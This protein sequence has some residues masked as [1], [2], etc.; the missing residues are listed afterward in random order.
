MQSRILGEVG[1]MGA[2]RLQQHRTVTGALV[3]ALCWLFLLSSSH[4][5][6]ADAGVGDFLPGQVIVKLQPT[7]V[8]IG[9]INASYSSTTLERFSDSSDVY[10]LQLPAG[11][12]V[13]DTVNQ[14][15]SDERLLYS[16]P[17]FVAESPE[18]DARHRAWGMS[19]DAPTSQDYA[20]T[21]L[22]LSAAH[23]ISLGKGT[24]VA[25]LDTGAQLD[26]PALLTNFEGVKRYDFVDDDKNPTERPVGAD[27]DGDGIK[28]DLF[29]H[30][31]HVAGIVDF[32][33]PNAKIM[34]LRVLDTEG[35][36]DVFTIAQAVSYAERNGADVM[37]LSLGSESRSKLLQQVIKD[38]TAHGVLVVAAAGNSN[39]SMP[40][41]PAA[42]NGVA[43]SANGL[44]A[45]TSVDMYSKKSDFANY[46]TWV[47]VSAPGNDIR[48]AF[49]V[50]SYAY[51]SGT[52]MATPFVSGEAALV[53]AVYGSLD[54]E[55]V[56]KRMRCSARPLLLIDPIYGAALGKGEADVGASLTPGVCS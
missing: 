55:S 48:S 15:T 10:L 7:G 36:G 3:F 49:P 38:A 8:R 43:A 18:G 40:H 47:D 28:D 50:D 24:T 34:P 27:T 37:N 6:Q 17:N 12:S 54:P 45:V 19:T 30:G 35:Y 51:W 16:E 11:S 2:R 32:V 21:A 53:H 5:A 9:D 52:S 22:N 13:Q 23:R 25:V 4:Y 26:H 39:S 42:G 41:Y 29:G 44:V 33:A 1:T 14:M 20:A 46:G 31:T 56:E